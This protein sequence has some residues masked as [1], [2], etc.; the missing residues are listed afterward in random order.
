MGFL[1]PRDEF[2]HYIEES[3]KVLTKKC[4]TLLMIRAVGFDGVMIVC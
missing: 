2:D 3:E 1:P 4:R